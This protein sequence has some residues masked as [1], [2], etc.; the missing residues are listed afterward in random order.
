LLILALLALLYIIFVPR[1]RFIDPYSTVITDRNGILLGARVAADGQWRFPAADSVPEKL[2]KA[3]LA[4][5]DRYFRFH[6]GINPVSVFRALLT[7]ISKG[8]VVSGGS[9]LT[10]QTIRLYRKGKARTVPEKLLEMIMAT[11]LEL[12]KSKSVILAM[13]VSHAPYGGNVVG[14]DAAAWRYFGTSSD[15]LSWAE[16][17]TLAILPNSPSLVHPGKNRQALVKKRDRLLKKLYRMG[18]IDDLT[19][20]TSLAEKIPEKPNAMPVSAPHLLNRVYKADPGSLVR[21]TID[22][23]LQAEVVRVI[24]THHKRLK[25]NE[26]HNAA[27][28]ILDV[29]T[30]NILAYVGNCGYPLERDHGNDVDII[31]AP[32]STGSL[33]KPLLFAAM[34]DDGKLLPYSLV[35]DIPVNLGGFSPRNFD[36]FFEGAVPASRALSRSLNVPAVEMLRVYGV[37]RFQHL[38]KSLGMST[39][40]QPAGHYGLSLILGGAEGTLEEMTNIYASLSR[41]LNHYGESDAYFSKEFRPV[42]YKFDN[43]ST[44]RKPAAQAEILNASSIW[45][46]YQAMIEVNR[47]EEET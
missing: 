7:N 38:L 19:F 17:S 12:E 34:I 1:C 47:P 18:W 20:E 16:A 44:A 24:E 27:A 25:Y 30:G 23:H 37:E 36:G 10:M 42:S 29:E 41:V 46:A 33:L 3:T 21:T 14:A 45:S 28:I 40:K 4:F 6:P 31:L 2:K 32:R 13:Y 11:R 39:L 5:E 8:R 15:R 35:P 26:I 43:P 22:A 9:T